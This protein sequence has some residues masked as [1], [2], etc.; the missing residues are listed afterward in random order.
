MR[1]ADITTQELANALGSTLFHSLWQ[2][3]LIGLVLWI[4]LQVLPRKSAQLKYWASITALCGIVFWTGL[5]L[6]DQIVP[7]LEPEPVSDLY[8]LSAWELSANLPATNAYQLPK[9]QALTQTAITWMEPYMSNFVGIWLIGMVFFLVRL[10]GSILYLSKMRTTN[11]KPVSAE[12]QWK[13]KELSL[14]LGI[15]KTVRIMESGLAEIPMVIGNL[16]PLILVPVGLLTGLAPREVEAVIAHELAHVKRYDYLINIVQ[17]VIESVLFFNPA[18]WLVSQAIRK[19][20]E[21]CCDD[22]AV[23]CCGNQMIYAHAL[24]NLGAWSLKPPVLSM[25]LF[26]SKNELFQRIKR[27]V[28]PQQTRSMKEKFVPA[29][30]LLMTFGCFTWYSL[31]VQAQFKP[32]EVTVLDLSATP[33]PTQVLNGVVAMDQVWDTIPELD[34]PMPPMEPEEVEDVDEPVEMEWVESDDVFDPVI[35]IMEEFEMSVVPDFEFDFNVVVPPIPDMA[36]VM[37]DVMPDVEVWVD[38][39]IEAFAELESMPEVWALPQVELADT[40]REKIQEIL[41]AHKEDIERARQDQAKAIERARAKLQETLKQDKPD[42][43]TEEE[44]ARAKEQ[45]RRAERQLERT[46]ED[47]ERSLE[48]ALEAKRN[49]FIQIEE[50]LARSAE[51]YEGGEYREEAMRAY[52]DAMRSMRDEQRHRDR[53]RNRDVFRHAEREHRE[54]ME[55][56]KESLKM[57]KEHLKRMKSDIKE[58]KKE[59]VKDGILDSVD[60]NLDISMKKDVLRING[61]KLTGSQYEKYDELLDDYLGWD[62]DGRIRINND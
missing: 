43:L 24:T 3:S 8:A 16:K 62:G 53:H 41:E 37:P 30:I 9:L 15:K 11:L 31:K 18:V 6:K 58:L 33:S 36:E 45:I 34:E 4:L 39:S 2:A 23:K 21:H 49:A 25:G 28:Y 7:L 51:I 52:R 54:G 35:E 14:Q 19:Q 32:K 26:K 57:H 10:Q 42:D 22:I 44:W 5:T 59:L 47:S 1:F 50:Q 20:R 48:R 40:S 29:M 27:L 38:A 12:W 55:H 17:T 13:V 46:M 60:D 61:K 56:Y